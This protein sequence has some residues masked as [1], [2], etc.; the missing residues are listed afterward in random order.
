MRV[1]SWVPRIRVPRPRSAE[2]GWLIIASALLGTIACLPCPAQDVPVVSSSRPKTK[3]P[4]GS[5]TGTVY[6]ADS[7]A[8]ARLAQVFAVPVS[9]TKFDNPPGMGVVDLDGHFAIGNLPEGK[10][11]IGAKQPGYPN[12]LDVLERKNDSL[13]AEDRKKLES[14]LA[15]VTISA[16][17]APEVAIRLE[18]GAEIDGTVLYDDGSP[19]VGL[20]VEL[21]DK[22]ERAEAPRQALYADYDVFAR[23]TDD[24]GRYRLVGVTPGEYLVSVTVPA[25]SGEEVAKNPLT[26]MMQS[27]SVGA[28]TVFYGDVFRPS[29]AT[30]VKIETAGSTANAD[31]T[32]PLSKL[33]TIRGHLVLKS[34]G[35]PPP[36]GGVLLKY[37]DTQENA[38]AGL[39]GEDGNFALYYVPEGSYILAAG[40]SPEPLPQFGGENDAVPVNLGFRV[41]MDDKTPQG[42]ASISLLVA[43]DLIGITLTV[44]DPPSTHPAEAPSPASGERPVA[45]PG[46]R[47]Q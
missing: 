5:V 7:N 11:Y 34:S 20:H 45:P 29:K 17:Q 35:D 27:T 10:Y 39:V 28:L 36:A 23:I 13:N 42:A 26:S 33:H 30:P 40:A 1:L 15:V 19:A 21:K 14:H 46:P 24:H 43:G 9:G 41:D 4:T 31:I 16:K 3:G 38:R 32:I 2:A 22:S 44:P 6:C 12:P 37:A 25:A 18:R 47:A 8:P